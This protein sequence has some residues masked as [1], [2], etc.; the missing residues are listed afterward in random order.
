MTNT[1]TGT[2]LVPGSRDVRGVF[3]ASDEST[4]S[5]RADAVVVACPPHPRHGGSRSDSRLTA[6]SAALRERG[7]DCL[8][9]DYGPWDEGRSER[10]D[11]R[12]ACRWAVERYDLVGVFGYSF[13]AT[14]ALLAVAD[15]TVEN[16]P[17]VPN[18]VSALAPDRGDFDADRDT[19]RSTDRDADG[20][21]DGDGGSRDRDAVT[22]LDRI[23]CP[24]QIVYGERDATVQWGPVVARARERD[25]VVESLPADHFFV[26]QSAKVGSRVASFLA[27][28]LR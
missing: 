16:A 17:E 14:V 24:V 18:A 6:V 19:G 12:N 28:A 15:A 10:L 27:S 23:A 1:D 26:G 4:R 20:D 22:A 3:D 2:V 8:R 11:T 7:I 13:G 5:G 21:G 9:F 25:L